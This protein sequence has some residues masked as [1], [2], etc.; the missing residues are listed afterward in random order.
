M[1]ESFDDLVG[2]T[3]RHSAVAIQFLDLGD[4]TKPDVVGVSGGGMAT[5]HFVDLIPESHIDLDRCRVVLQVFSVEHKGPG[6][7]NLM[8]RGLIEASVDIP[9]AFK[10]VKVVSKLFVR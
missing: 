1:K 5:Q 9:P 6:A 4:G 8:A 7:H 10:P 3:W 2:N